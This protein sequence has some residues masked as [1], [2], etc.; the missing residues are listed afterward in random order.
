MT[1]L[2]LIGASGLAQETIAALRSNA[3]PRTLRILDDSP[4]TWGT[5]IDGVSVAGGLEAA[6]EHPGAELLIC[7][8]R[9][10]ARADLAARLVRTGVTPDRFTVLVHRSVDV[11]PGCRI[12]AGSIVLAGAVLTANVTIGAHVVVMPHVTLT[13]GVRIDSYATLCAGVTLGGDVHIGAA[14]YLGMNVAVRE[15]V[16]VGKRAVIG[17]GAAVLT[18]VPADETWLGVPARP[19]L[20]GALV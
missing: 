6:V 8:G 13:H 1:E 4:A 15:R 9:G 10:S 2:I 16:T 18:D 5:A 11:P 12:D 7:V 17:M 20:K 3:D 19:Q 14:G